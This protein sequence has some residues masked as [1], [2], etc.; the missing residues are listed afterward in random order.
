VGC[1]GQGNVIAALQASQAIQDLQPELIVF[2]GTAGGLKEGVRL[3][4]VVFATK[5]Y[6]YERGKQTDERLFARPDIALVDPRT[7]AFARMIAGSD[8]WRPDR[9][10]SGDD[11]ELASDES[12]GPR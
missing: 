3:G 1:I 6:G 2:L 11:L 12:I 7:A 5:V 4:D 8:K 10:A 9:A